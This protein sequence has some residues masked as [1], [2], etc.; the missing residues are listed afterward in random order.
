MPTA[1]ALHYSPSVM[2]LDQYEPMQPTWKEELR[3]QTAVKSIEKTPYEYS[4]TGRV[5][6]NLF[7]VSKEVKEIDNKFQKELVKLRA[8][9]LRKRQLILDRRDRI[10]AG[11]LADELADYEFTYLRSFTN[12]EGI[13]KNITRFEEGIE[14]IDEE[15]EK[16]K[17]R[18]K[19]EQEK[20]DEKSMSATARSGF[21]TMNKLGTEKERSATP[22][23]SERP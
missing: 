7:I 4:N 9:M 3:T 13:A 14:E 12:V 8:K 2:Q 20:E 16:E 18:K 23:K 17:Q 11:D 6:K 5:L 22:T 15:A 1:K 21:T 10:L 19:E